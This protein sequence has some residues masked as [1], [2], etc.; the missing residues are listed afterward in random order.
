MS[1]SDYSVPLLE[2]ADLTVRFGNV[3]ALDGL[4]LAVPSGEVLALLGP[5][6][7]G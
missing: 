7:A 3:T 1:S 4:N 2:A 6:G 5:N